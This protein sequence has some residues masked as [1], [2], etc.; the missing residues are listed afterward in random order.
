VKEWTEENNLNYEPSTA[1]SL[2]HS[3]RNIDLSFSKMTAISCETLHFDTSDHWSRA[4]TY[5][6]F[7]SDMRGTFSHRN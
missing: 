4:L 5:E 7:F 1:Q 3:M 2:K 6:K